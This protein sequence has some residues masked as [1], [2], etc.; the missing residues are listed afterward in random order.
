MKIS[1]IDAIAVTVE[2]GL[3]LSLIIGRDFALHLSRTA[4]KPVIPIH[5]MKAHALTVRMVEKVIMNHFF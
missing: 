1:D 3:P 4:N 2:P 5:H